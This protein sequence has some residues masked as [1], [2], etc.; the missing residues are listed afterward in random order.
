[1][2]ERRQ[3]AEGHGFSRCSP[4]SL[5]HVFGWFACSSRV[6]GVC[7]SIITQALTFALMLACVRNGMAFG[8][9]NGFTDFK[10]IIGFD[11]HSD[12]PHVALLLTS[13]LALAASSLA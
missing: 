3:I 11:L 9:N 12:R 6:T 5:A 10:D 13:I 2:G 4:P 7:F 8:G 1:M